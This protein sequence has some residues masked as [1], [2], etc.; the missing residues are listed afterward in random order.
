[1]TLVLGVVSNKEVFAKNT[2][3]GLS[4]TDSFLNLNDI[5]MEEAFAGTTTSL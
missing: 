4:D 3:G 2:R 1:M 5:E